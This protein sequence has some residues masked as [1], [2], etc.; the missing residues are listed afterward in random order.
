MKKNFP[1]NSP[2]YH[3]YRPTFSQ[4]SEDT[5]TAKHDRGL[6][7]TDTIQLLQGL[8][9]KFYVFDHA[10]ITK[11]ASPHT[12]TFSKSLKAASNTALCRLLKN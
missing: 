7:F 11:C 12:K 1:N 2:F 8:F 4:R 3:S 6:L 5:G 9:L 10:K